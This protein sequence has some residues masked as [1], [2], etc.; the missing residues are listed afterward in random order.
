[1]NQATPE[2][3]CRAVSLDLKARGY[4]Q[5]KTADTIGKSRAIVSNL[6]SSKK[7]FSKQMAVLFN[8]AF[9]YNV[10]YLLYGE[11]QLLGTQVVHDIVEL[12][13]SGDANKV[14]EDYMILASLIDI[15]EDIIRIAGDS[16]ALGAWQAVMKGNFTGYVENMDRLA[17]AHN[18]E[19]YSPILARFACDKIKDKVY[20]P[21]IEK[22]ERK[23]QK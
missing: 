3:V 21:I 19:H 6:L 10:Q 20:L 7:R 2:E 1:M 17:A 16:N 22:I 15:A 9:G 11:G 14:N 23:G 5:Q 4:T 12:P 13:V 8:R 18:G